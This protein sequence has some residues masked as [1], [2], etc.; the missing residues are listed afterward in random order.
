MKQIKI[1]LKTNEQFEIKDITKDVQ[2]AVKS[3]GIQDG[4]VVVFSPHTTAGVK[5]NHYEPLLLQDLLRALYRLF[6]QDVNYNHDLFELRQK[7]DPDQRSN[8]HAHV[9]SFF[10]ETSQTIPIQSGNLMLGDRQS[11]LFVECDGSRDREV[12]LIFTGDAS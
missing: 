6:P 1:S 12:M 10:L 2:E 5:L 8:G 3:S 9:K 11:V 4:M 7:T